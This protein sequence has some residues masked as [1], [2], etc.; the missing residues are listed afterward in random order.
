MKGKVAVLL[1]V[2]LA[3]LSLN[4]LAAGKTVGCPYCDSEADLV[5]YRRNDGETHYCVYKCRANP[6]EHVFTDTVPEAHSYTRQAAK[7]CFLASA[8]TCT[9]PAKYYFSCVC[10]AKSTETF[11]SGRPLDH[12]FTNYVSNNDATC[13]KDGT[14]TAVC[15]RPGCNTKSTVPDEG[16]HLAAKHTFGAWYQNPHDKEGMLEHDCKVCGVGRYRYE[17]PLRTG[18]FPVA[19]TLVN[20]AKEAAEG[21]EWFIV[22]SDKI[23]TPEELEAMGALSPMEQM[24][25]FTSVIGYEDQVDQLI[26]YRA[27][28]MAET[29]MDLPQKPDIEIKAL[30]EMARE[31]AGH[32]WQKGTPLRADELCR[33]VLV[34][35]GNAFSEEAEALKN[36]IQRRIAALRGKEVAAFQTA[37]DT[38]FPTKIIVLDPYGGDYNAPLLTVR[39]TNGGETHEETYG[40]RRIDGEWSFCE[41]I[42]ETPEQESEDA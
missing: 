7:R 8:A 13:V 2:L 23:L 10:C 35:N 29:Q 31:N 19:Q 41:L 15:D 30:P 20:A 5:G 25:V 32:G 18:D 33:P 40:F 6:E 9:E 27:E 39:V 12:S 38:Y 36:A 16:S 24:L 26:K 28:D 21:E 1:A 22:D 17:P 42:A 4:A 14:K 11:E 3:V 37:L 34:K